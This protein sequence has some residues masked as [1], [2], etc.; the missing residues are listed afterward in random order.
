V[1]NIKDDRID[2]D[3]VESMDFDP[4]HLEKYR[5]QPGDILI[6]EGQSPELLGQSAIYRGS[7]P[8]LCFQ[9]TLHRFRPI[10]QG[11]SSEFAQIVFRS[12]VKNGVFA[13]LGSIT[14]NIAHLTLK[15][16]KAS[17][18]PLPPAAEQRRIVAEVSRLL[19]VADEVELEVDKGLAHSGRLR[20]GILATAFRGQLVA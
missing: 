19:S 2:F 6:S 10:A 9:K 13:K 17:P 11:P 18:F 14:T 7:V 16:F 1:A 4:A 12:H 3:D 15:R 5:L 8:E 20:E